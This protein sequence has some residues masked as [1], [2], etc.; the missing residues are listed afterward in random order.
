VWCY[1]CELCVVLLLLK[2]AVCVVLV[3]CGAMCGA[4]CGAVCVG[5][6]INGASVWFSS[7]VV[8]V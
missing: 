6:I 3:L 1:Y 7:N 2:V 8:T 4:V 5:A